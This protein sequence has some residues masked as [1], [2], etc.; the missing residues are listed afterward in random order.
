LARHG[1]FTILAPLAP[2]AACFPLLA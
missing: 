1:E 2:I